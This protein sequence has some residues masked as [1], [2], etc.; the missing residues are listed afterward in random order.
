ME[1]VVAFLAMLELVKRRQ[2]V[3]RQFELFGEIELVPTET[4]NDEADFELEF[5]E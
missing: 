2:V 1:V 5:G 3:A 4:W